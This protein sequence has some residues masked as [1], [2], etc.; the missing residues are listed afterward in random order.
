MRYD[1]RP[2]SFVEILDQ[3]F[4][5][6]RD[7]FVSLAG[8]MVVL[9]VP[10]TF[11]MSLFSP[12]AEGG[13]RPDFGTTLIA[14]GLT[15]VLMGF[16]APLAQMAVTRTTADAYLGKSIGLADALRSGLK[17]YGSYVG[18]YF[19]M[20]LFVFGAMLLLVIPGVYL[21]VGYGLVGPVVVVEHI[22]GR[23]ALKRSRALVQD[24][25]W[26][27]FAIV[28]VA[29]LLNA[30]VAGAVN[31]VIGSVPLIGPLL[32]GVVQGVGG[33]FVA[34]VIVVYYFD[35]RCRKEDFDLTI[36][37]QQVGRDGTEALPASTTAAPG[38]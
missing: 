24:N 14:L 32:V 15:I 18:T 35:L 27:T 30:V 26:R 34:V 20:L 5:L 22:V 12:K 19:L 8:V 7:H 3:S 6:L 2:R 37:A 21:G 13:A 38:L 25:W 4:R 36:L 33:A 29:S 16:I 28:A 17:I 11:V 31:L 1:L 23:A 9:M 10:Y